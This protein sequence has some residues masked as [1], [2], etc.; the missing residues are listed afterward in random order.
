MTT[1]SDENQQTAVKGTVTREE[2]HFRRIDMRGFKRSDG[3]FEIEGRVVDRKPRDFSPRFG[4]SVPANQPIHDLGV[5]LVFDENM[6][7]LEVEAFT[8]AAPYTACPEG[9]RALQAIKGAR[10]SSGWTRE[11]R[12]RLGRAANCAHL[13]E[14]LIPLATAAFQSVSAERMSE[15][16]PVNHEGR[17]LKIDSCHAYAAHGDLVKLRWPEFHQSEQPKE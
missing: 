6:V 2:L 10:M 8:N 14:I 13:V 16:D 5:R 11:V 1:P 17:P 7:V 9:G 3:L 4:R 12:S 15:P